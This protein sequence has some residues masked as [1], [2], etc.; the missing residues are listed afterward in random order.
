MMMMMK[1]TADL[2]FCQM[3]DVMSLPLSVGCLS[4]CLSAR[5]LKKLGMEFDEIFFWRGEGVSPLPTKNQLD[6]GADPDHNPDLWF[7]DLYCNPD[8]R[9]FL[10]YFKQLFIYRTIV[11]RTDNQE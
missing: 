9:V 8:Q 4:N 11:I 2:Q 10:L 1:S 5:L 6:F 3:T 7:P